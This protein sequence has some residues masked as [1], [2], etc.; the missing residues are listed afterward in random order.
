MGH[1]ILGYNK[2]GGE[3]AY[4]RFSM[5]NHNVTVLYRLLDATQYDAGVSGSGNSATYTVPQLENAL[6][7]FNQSFGEIDSSSKHHYTV[8][9]LKQIRDFIV[10][11]LATA[12]NEGSVKIFFC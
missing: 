7:L 1:D 4:A 6:N 11:C 3:I 9:D 10:N 12:K 8:W 5:S 2:A